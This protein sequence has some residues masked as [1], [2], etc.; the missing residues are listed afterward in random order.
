MRPRL[1]ASFLLLFPALACAQTSRALLI[2]IDTYEPPG[3]TAQ[4]PSGCAYGRC[5]LGSFDNLAGA[6]NDALSMADLLTSPRFGFPA[7][8][9]VLLTNPAPPQPRPSADKAQDA[10]VPPYP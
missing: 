5:E 4:H 9:V 1:I 10:A 3:T 6:V 8:R 2:G 7:D